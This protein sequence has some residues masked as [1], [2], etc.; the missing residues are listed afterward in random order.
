MCSKC[1]PT[2]FPAPPPFPSRRPAPYYCQHSTSRAAFSSHSRKTS[3]LLLAFTHVARVLLTLEEGGHS[4]RRESNTTRRRARTF[5]ARTRSRSRSTRSRCPFF[6]F[7]QFFVLPLLLGHRLNLLAVVYNSVPSDVPLLEH[8]N[9]RVEGV[10][11]LAVQPLQVLEH[12]DELVGV[13][14]ASFVREL[15]NN[16][17][18]LEKICASSSFGSISFKRRT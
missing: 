4:R 11:L 12:F 14:A 17:K 5:G 16:A 6:L 3:L 18:Q 13:V 2:T 1:R 8:V 15:P 7:L 9:T 10:Q